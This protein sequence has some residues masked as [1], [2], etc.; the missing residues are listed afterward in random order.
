MTG[1]SVTQYHLDCAITAARDDIVSV[2]NVV[3]LVDK[4]G[5]ASELFQDSPRLQ[6]V[7]S[8]IWSI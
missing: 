1:D 8:F 4:G 7:N 5:V 2:R 3:G 6:S